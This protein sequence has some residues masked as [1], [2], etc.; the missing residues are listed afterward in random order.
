MK[1]R[2]VDQGNG[3]PRNVKT[4]KRKSDYGKLS[5]KINL[6]K[7]RKG[8]GQGQGR[9]MKNSRERRKP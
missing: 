5:K 9:E 3:N 7:K 2:E 4:L 1:E 6:K 8:Q